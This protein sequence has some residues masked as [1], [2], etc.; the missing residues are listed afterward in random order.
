MVNHAEKNYTRPGTHWS[1]WIPTSA[2]AIWPEW[3]R[4]ASLA[5]IGS[6]QIIQ[7][8]NTKHTIPK[9]FG[10]CA[11]LCIAVLPLS[12]ATFGKFTYVDNGTSITITGYPY[13]ASGA[14]VIPATIGG[15]PVTII[16]HDAFAICRGLTSVTIPTSVTSIEHDA[17]SNCSGLPTLTIPNSVTRIGFNAFYGCDGLKSVTIPSSVTSIGPAAFACG[18]LKVIVVDALNP[19]YSS[20]NG[21]LFDHRKAKL[22]QYPGGKTGNYTIPSSV[23][24]IGH[25]AFYYGESLTSVTIPT[26]VTSIGPNAF[27]GC[28][29]LTS[30]TIPSSVISIGNEAFFICSGLTTVTISRG[31]TSIGLDAFY[32]CDEL[33]SVHIPSS[34][35]S[36]GQGAFQCGKLTEINVDALNP[37]YSSEDGVL[38]DGQKTTLVQYPMAKNGDYTIPSGVTRIEDIAFYY[39]YRIT[40]LTFPSSLT[41]IGEYAF[42]DCSLTSLKFP[43]S[44]TSFGKGAFSNCYGIKSVTIPSGVTN[45]G[46]NAFESCYGLKNVTIGSGVTNIGKNAFYYCTSLTK[47][48]FLGNAP[49]LGLGPFDYAASGFSI[50][51]INGHTGFTSPTWKGYP[52]VGIA[53][54]PEIDVQQPLGSSLVYGKARKSFGTVV[55]GQSGTAKTFTLINTGTGKLTG[56]A[57]SVDGTNAGD[58]VIT[59][60]AKTTLSPGI[61]TTFKVTFKPT[62]S[63][64]RSAA[65]HIQSNDAN[66]N[67]FDIKLTGLGSAP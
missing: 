60:P 6:V 27:H 50:N 25:K 52:C 20:E 26:S 57:F 61:S 13:S 12:A 63:G 67:P 53:A 40:G 55:V 10:V 43:N 41:S 15:K 14:V 4:Q 49:K 44:L 17:F 18:K 19:K 54:A 34:V 2:L 37:N 24:S 33:T 3:S 36:I 30:V 11:A 21:V 31:V 62:A 47:A 58:F 35:T 59:P 23:S 66:E 22:V 45:I 56:L 29:G 7:A 65:I 46:D 28:S 32:A 1:P 39:C 9:L 8:M 51:Y 5:A 42:Y 64:T 48:T 16:G 38:F